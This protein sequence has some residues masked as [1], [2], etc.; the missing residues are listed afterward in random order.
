MHIRNASHEGRDFPNHLPQTMLRSPRSRP[1]WIG[2]YRS[3]G[4]RNDRI[5]ALK[6]KQSMAPTRRTLRLERMARPPILM[7]QKRNRCPQRYLGASSSQQYPY[8]SL[9]LE[10]QLYLV[11]ISRAVY[12]RQI[13]LG[14]QTTNSKK[15]AHATP[16]H[17]L[18]AKVKV[19]RHIA[20]HRHWQ[21][22]ANV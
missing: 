20:G 14:R 8:M 18:A 19:Q 13:F 4:K 11:N 1:T 7:I 6:P 16:L 15:A 21:A 10:C 22:M 2:A 17:L 9:F 3:H 5:K 12:Q